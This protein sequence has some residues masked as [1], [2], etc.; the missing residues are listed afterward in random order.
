VGK[1]AAH[2][3]V[4]EGEGVH[5]C[6]PPAPSSAGGA[7]DRSPR[8]ACALRHVLAPGGEDH[9]EDHPNVGGGAADPTEA[10]LLTRAFELRIRDR[11]G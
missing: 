10:F 8:K 6:R 5:R 2:A 4:L 3:E 7:Q 1:S 11:N 9:R